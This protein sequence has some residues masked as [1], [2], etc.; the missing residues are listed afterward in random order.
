MWQ[1]IA[2]S[3]GF[4]V[5]PAEQE[6]I[7]QEFQ[8]LKQDIPAIT[9]LHAVLQRT[10][11]AV[12]ELMEEP[13]VNA[14]VSMTIRES[15]E[16]WIALLNH[17][18]RVV[19]DRK[20]AAPAIAQLRQIKEWSRQKRQAAALI[21]DA[22]EFKPK[23][24]GVG[25]SVLAGV[26]E[27]WSKEFR[28]GD[29]DQDWFE[30]RR[31]RL[32][33]LQAEFEPPAES[34]EAQEDSIEV[35]EDDP[36]T[37]FYISQTL[38]ECRD[39]TMALHLD[40]EEVRRFERQRWDLQS[41]QNPGSNQAL[42]REIN[43]FHQ[44]LLEKATE[45]KEGRL[46]ALRV[47]WKRFQEIYDDGPYRETKELVDIAERA[48]PDSTIGMDQF[49]DRISEALNKI[50]FTVDSNRPRMT[51]A[52]R[53]TSELCRAAVKELRGQPR[54]LLLDSNL[55]KQEKKI[56]ADGGLPTDAEQSFVCLEQC[57][58]VRIELQL[59]QQENARGSG[60]DRGEG[61]ASSLDCLGDSDGGEPGKEGRG[62]AA[63]RSP[64]SARFHVRVA[65]CFDGLLE[66]GGKAPAEFSGGGEDRMYRGGVAAAKREHGLDTPVDGG[67]SWNGESRSTRVR[68]LPSLGRC[69]R[70]WRRKGFSR[71]GSGSWQRRRWS[72]SARRGGHVCLQLREH[73][74]RPSFET[75]P[76]RGRAEKLLEDLK[77][78]PALAA[79]P[80]QSDFS[81]SFGLIADAEAFIERL[82]SMRREIPARMKRLEERLARLN[83]LD[84]ASFHQTTARRVTALLQGMQAAIVR[85]QFEHLRFQMEE[86]RKLIV[87]LETDVGRR[88]SAET[89]ERRARLLKAVKASKDQQFSR[90]AESVLARL[91]ANG[92]NEA[93]PHSLR[94]SLNSI[95]GW[96][97]GNR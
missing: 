25:P 96:S 58:A 69:K 48:L 74:A 82:E 46:D 76:E 63:G 62:G 30:E 35:I 31:L 20:G 34:T 18:M 87:A 2:A 28:L 84:A 83:E 73:L 13:P 54:S 89:E 91:D 40:E 11:R 24:A 60:P 95:L 1:R 10:R 64:R 42:L 14:T 21:R 37:S 22:V 19:S 94:R 61:N 5:D 66:P 59:L 93:P 56:P 52:I 17:I 86:A 71:S 72:R 29:V 90:R 9:E 12:N 3:K 88:V 75:H 36:M 27:A 67:G 77:R 6:R 85:D 68:C 16:E 32:K 41:D 49:F 51:Q 7:R 15:S 44:E 53:R 81:E 33:G 26:E 8:T 92:H 70:R 79:E 65:G 4:N 38:S 80:A 45:E 78:M 43:L 55:T 97:V 47:R 50:Y 23:A 39:L 57:D